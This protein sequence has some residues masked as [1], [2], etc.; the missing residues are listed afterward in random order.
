VDGERLRGH[1]VYV[2][3]ADHHLLV[4]DGRVHVRRGP[5]ENGH[6]PAADPLF[7]SAARYYGPRVVGVVLSGMLHDGA[8]GLAAVKREGGIGVVQHP[9]DALCD[10]M[11]R[12]ALEAVDADH[13]VPA[14]EI[15]PLLA[16]LAGDD[17]LDGAAPDDEMRPEVA[18]TELD[19]GVVEGDHRGRPSPWPC[20]DCSGVLWEVADDDVL[21]FRCRVGHHW[22]AESLLQEQGSEVETALWA[23]LRALEDR[24]ALSRTMADR[25]E[26][27]G[28]SMSARRFRSEVDHMAVSIDVLRRLLQ[29]GAP[30]EGI[31]EAADG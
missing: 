21:Q 13:V 19:D 26:T 22:A 30:V 10:S 20:P 15:G 17:V 28:R 27:S 29:V 9:D 16:R 11:P 8:A 24:A 2:C 6:R 12:S 4:G 31:G 18:L 5:R 7:R 25:A 1:Q 14:R 3:A 23:A